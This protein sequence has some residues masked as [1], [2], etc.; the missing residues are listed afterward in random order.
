MI[1]VR[2]PVAKYHEIMV[3]GNATIYL[4]RLVKFSN[5]QTLPKNPQPNDIALSTISL[6]RPVKTVSGKVHERGTHQRGSGMSTPALSVPSGNCPL[7]GRLTRH[8]ETSA[9]IERTLAKGPIVAARR[10]I[11]VDANHQSLQTL[12]IS[13]KGGFSSDSR[14]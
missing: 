5:R 6:G 3:S 11:A 4:I 7:F 1:P 12:Q 14:E 8:F 9:A 2:M 13:K 10:G